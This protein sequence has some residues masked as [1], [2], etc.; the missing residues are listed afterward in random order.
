MLLVT[1]SS[2]S[3]RVPIAI[4]TIQMG[5][6]IKLATQEELGKLSHCWKRAAVL[7]GAVL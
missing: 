7:T 1:D 5:M 3:N 4:C 2:Y 6:L